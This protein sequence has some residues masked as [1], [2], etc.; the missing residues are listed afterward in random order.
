MRARIGGKWN[1]NVIICLS[2]RLF[3]FF[4]LIYWSPAS[5]HFVLI[6]P[7]LDYLWFTPCFTSTH[8]SDAH[9]P[10]SPILV[11]RRSLLHL[12]SSTPILDIL[13]ILHALHFTDQAKPIRAWQPLPRWPTHTPLGGRCFIAHLCTTL[14]SRPFAGVTLH[15]INGDGP[16][17]PITPT[18]TQCGK[19][20][21]GRPGAPAF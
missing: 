4:F 20:I 7:G 11:Q 12:L 19:S 15:C 5:V 2:W 3:F 13:C 8:F 1:A 16:V 10:S 9:H 17:H 6:V 18:Q 14:P 21:S